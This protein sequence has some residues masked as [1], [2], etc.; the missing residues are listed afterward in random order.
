MNNFGYGGA[1][2]HAVL[3]AFPIKNG[4]V[5]HPLIDADFRDRLIHPTSEHRVFVLSSKDCTVTKSMMADL[6]D[7]LDTD[8]DGSHPLDLASL[9]YTLA[10]R[11]SIHPWRR[12]V[13]ANS[14]SE[15]ASALRSTARKPVQARTAPRIGY[16]FTGQGA[17]WATMGKELFTY[18][19]FA[20]AMRDADD[21]LK[22]YGAEWS[23]IGN[24]NHGTLPL[25][26]N[27]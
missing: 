3:E 15:L 22:S 2:A 8:A 21:V 27:S 4:D 1:N 26:S 12:A 16:V 19:V 24:V 13:S 14:A 17:Q 20:A 25:V 23:L 18:P 10:E 11:R 9:A 6:A 5:E 7:Y